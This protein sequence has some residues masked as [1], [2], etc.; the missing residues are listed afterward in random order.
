MLKCGF[1]LIFE[2]MRPILL[3]LIGDIDVFYSS[4]EFF[5]IAVLQKR[6]VC[7]FGDFLRQQEVLAGNKINAVFR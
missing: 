2:V 6:Q 1:Y 4:L 5:E 7:I 3:F